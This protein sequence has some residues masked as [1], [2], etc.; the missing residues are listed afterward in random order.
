M[1]ENEPR[2]EG[3]KYVLLM[4]GTQVHCVGFPNKY[5]PEADMVIVGSTGITVFGALSIHPNDSLRSSGGILTFYI[6]EI[7]GRIWSLNEIRTGMLKTCDPRFVQ[8]YLSVYKNE[9]FRL[10]IPEHVIT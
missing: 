6:S 3:Y 4:S 10:L 5:A 7:T 2:R 1:S 9:I 8:S